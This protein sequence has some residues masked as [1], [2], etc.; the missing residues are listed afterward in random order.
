MYFQLSGFF[1]YSDYSQVYVCWHQVFIFSIRVNYLRNWNISM[2]KTFVSSYLWIRKVYEIF[3]NIIQISP[4]CRWSL[5]SI[6]IGACISIHLLSYRPCVT[7]NV[8]WRT[9]YNL[10]PPSRWLFIFFFCDPVVRFAYFGCG[11][12]YSNYYHMR[13]I[14]WFHIWR[15]LGLACG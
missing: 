14:K 1:V 10:F 8:K 9:T 6:C 11:L 4:L 13:K 7:G 5:G 15:E 2:L 3:S 12:S